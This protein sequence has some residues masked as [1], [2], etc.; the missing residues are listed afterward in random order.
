MDLRR[1]SVHHTRADLLLEDGNAKA[2]W[3]AIEPAVDTFKADVVETA[4]AVLDGLGRNDEAV[5]LAKQY[6]DRYT[7]EATGDCLLARLAWRRGEDAAAARIL[8]SASLRPFDWQRCLAPSFYAVFGKASRER[9]VSAF[10]SVARL[11]GGQFYYVT[12]MAKPFHE[13]GD[14]ETAHELL[15][16]ARAGNLHDTGLML[17][18]YDELEHAR[19][20]A[21]AR[22]WVSRQKIFPVN[23]T[24]FVSIIDRR[25]ELVWSGKPGEAPTADEPLWTLRTAAFV[26]RGASDEAERRILHDHFA[27]ASPPSI[28]P[29]MGRYLLADSDEAALA[30]ARNDLHAVN[31]IAWVKALRAAAAGRG[32]EANDWVQVAFET[33]DE[34]RPAVAFCIAMVQHWQSLERYPGSMRPAE[35]L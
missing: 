20:E 11:A 2:A 19:G 18:A 7:V 16:A 32:D 26:H 1:A 15:W 35:L 13:H 31:S 3:Q 22:E 25:F 10:Q 24:S 4:V 33:N 5:A 17:A 34:G 14:H 12:T 6:K 21:A 9:T 29:A 30:A 28:W 8:Q 23:D 27:A